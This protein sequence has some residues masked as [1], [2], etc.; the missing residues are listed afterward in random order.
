MTAE[1]F[2]IRLFGNFELH[3]SE[4]NASLTLKSRKAV[5]LIAYLARQPHRTQSRERVAR[6]L[7]E[8]RPEDLARASLRQA[9]LAIRCLAPHVELIKEPRADCLSLDPAVRVDADRLD[10]ALSSPDVPKL[11][12][13]IGL[14]R[15]DLLEGLRIRSDG[16]EIWLATERQRL[17]SLAINAIQTLLE[18]RELKSVDQIQIALKALA[19]DPA[20]ETAHRTLIRLYAT[21]G[22]R[23]EA[24]RQYF[25]CR[26]TLWKEFATRPEPATD[27]LYRA[28]LQ[29]RLSS[30]PA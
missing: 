5:A 16:F 24:L 17:R 13:A 9:L 2:E 25:R 11:I 6:L 1:A 10:D 26:D 4:S 30:L 23:A 27:T 12:E 15:G 28:V 29:H 8:D 20:Q 14:I 18:A 19:L 3:C 21:T 7:W 22:R